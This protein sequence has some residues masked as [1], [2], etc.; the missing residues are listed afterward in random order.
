M[1]V[2]KKLKKLLLVKDKQLWYIPKC[3]CT[4]SSLHNFF[5]LQNQIH[6]FY[7][8]AQTAGSV[9]SSRSPAAIIVLTSASIPPNWQ[10]TILFFWLLHVRLDK[11]PAEQ[12]TILTSL[13]PRSPTKPC[14]KCSIL[15][16][17]VPASERFRSVQRQFCT[18]RVL[19]WF[20]WIERAC[21]PPAS[22]IAGLLLEHTDRTEKK[23][24]TDL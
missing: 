8:K 2:P 10:T 3:N 6:N 16:S 17:L 20:K 21:M 1:R 22:T 13:L 9:I 24:C 15:S 11:M 14:I 7:L 19:A 12:V 23:M 18:N 4:F 5:F